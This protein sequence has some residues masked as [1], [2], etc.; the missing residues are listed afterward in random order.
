MRG[1]KYSLVWWK[2]RFEKGYAL[3]HYIFKLIAVLG[4]TSQQTKLT[5]ILTFIYSMSCFVVGI[6]WYKYGFVVLEKEIENQNDLF[7]KE[8]RKRKV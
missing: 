7:V 2:S 5:F 4:L 1:K 6:L 8:M 3:S